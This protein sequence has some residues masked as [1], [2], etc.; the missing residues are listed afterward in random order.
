MIN[1]FDMSSIGED[2]FAGFCFA[3]AS[4]DML[5]TT[6]DAAGL[7]LLAENE[8]MTVQAMPSGAMNASVLQAA[9]ASASAS[10]RAN[11]DARRLTTQGITGVFG[12]PLDRIDQ[13]YYP[14]DGSYNYDQV[15]VCTRAQRSCCAVTASA[16]LTLLQ[17]VRTVAQLESGTHQLR[18]LSSQRHVL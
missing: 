12:W 7:L 14:L 2:G 18:L 10:D 8:K 11:R 9:S 3:A 16:A 5:T 13:P 15:R 4:A 1:T 17:R 6:A